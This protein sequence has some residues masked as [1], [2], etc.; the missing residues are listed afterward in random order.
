MHFGNKREYSMA[1]SH[2]NLPGADTAQLG[3]DAP[4]AREFLG[5]RAEL[6]ATLPPTPVRELLAAS[7]ATLFVLATDAAFVAAIRRAAAD[8]YPLVIVERWAELKQ[9]ADSGRCGIALLDAAVLGPRVTE[10]IAIL[11]AYADRLVT[12]VAADRAAAQQYVGLLSGGRVYRLLIKPAAVGAIAGAGTAAAG[13]ATSAVTP[14]RSHQPSRLPASAA[15]SNATAHTLA[16]TAQPHFGN[17]LDAATTP[18]GT[19]SF[20]AASRSCKR[21]AVADSINKRVAPTAAGVISSR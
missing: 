5:H 21:R 13:S 11:A 20:A 3:A 10:C 1:A 4:N 16:P 2:E 9:A 7:G 6:D 18:V 12:L 19:S 8:R 14:K 17:L 15:P